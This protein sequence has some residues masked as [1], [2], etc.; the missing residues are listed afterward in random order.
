M[1]TPWGSLDTQQAFRFT[2]GV[3]NIRV[4]YEHGFERC[5]PE[6]KR[7]ALTRLRHR[8]NF[9]KTGIPDRAT[10]F[11]IAEGGTFSLSSAGPLATGIPEVDAV[12]QRPA[13]NFRAPAVA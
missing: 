7:A 10:S 11:A 5:P 3:N 4:A 13:Y 9:N 6:I 12:L 2:A 1:A 8:L